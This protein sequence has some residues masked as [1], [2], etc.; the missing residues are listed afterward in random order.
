[1]QNAKKT[2]DRYLK[3]RNLCCVGGTSKVESQN[4]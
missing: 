4:F 3:Y 1:M 2:I